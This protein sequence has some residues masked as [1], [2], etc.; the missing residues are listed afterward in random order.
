[1]VKA[2]LD[3]K[4]EAHLCPKHL[5][6]MC[7]DCCSR[8]ASSTPVLRLMIMMN[9]MQMMEMQMKMKRMQMMMKREESLIYLS[10]KSFL[11]QMRKALTNV[12]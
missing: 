8:A 1:M 9:M 5:D 12:P 10:S 2:V 11:Q 3:C 7:E 4:V 6:Q